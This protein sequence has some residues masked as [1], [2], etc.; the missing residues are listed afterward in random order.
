MSSECLRVLHT[1]KPIKPSYLHTYNKRNQVIHRYNNNLTSV[2]PVYPSLS[3]LLQYNITN[4]LIFALFV[5][6]Q[7][8]C[9][10]PL[11]YP[12]IYIGFIF[13]LP[14]FYITL[15]LP[16]YIHWFYPHFTLMLHYPYF[17]LILP[18]Y[19]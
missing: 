19:L 12:H 11:F 8:S 9:L 7:Q 14:S 2:A 15:I 4:T 5:K 13:I 10:L 16:S 1:N 18:L 17:T 3:L 6:M